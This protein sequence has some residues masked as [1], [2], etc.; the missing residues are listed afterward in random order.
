[1]SRELAG[2]F[3]TPESPRKPKDPFTKAKFLEVVALQTP[4]ASSAFQAPGFPSIDLSTHYFLNCS[5]CSHLLA[6]CCSSNVP[7]TPPSQGFCSCCFISFLHI[8]GP[9]LASSWFNLAFSMRL[10]N[11]NFKRWPSLSAFLPPASMAPSPSNNYIFNHVCIY[12]VQ[13]MVVC[14]LFP[15]VFRIGEGNG[16]PLQ[17]SCLENPMDGGAWKAAVHG[18]AEGRT[19]LSD[20]TFTFHFPAL[21]KE[22]TTHSSVL[23]WRIPGMGEPGGLPSMGS[24]RVGHDWS[25]LAVAATAFRM[26]RSCVG[27]SCVCFCVYCVS[28]HLALAECLTH[29]PSIHR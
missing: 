12:F 8:M 21:E 23:A 18:V 10:F 6:S 5:L 24:H 19:W 27:V 3:F 29:R 20:F 1:M 22:M 16:T 17:Y 4:P 9:K 13:N 28:T 11:L 25:D 15:P 2:G 26:Q 14:I 7:S